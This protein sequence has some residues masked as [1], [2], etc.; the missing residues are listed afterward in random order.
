[1]VAATARE[2]GRRE[3]RCDYNRNMRFRL[4]T[5]LIVVALLPPLIA[6]AWFLSRTEQ[7]SMI[8]A[9]IAVV[10]IYFVASFWLSPP[11][12]PPND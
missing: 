12:D 8:L 7:G 10:A 9:L 1:M 5:L 2:C 4:R 11:T 3:L 6:G